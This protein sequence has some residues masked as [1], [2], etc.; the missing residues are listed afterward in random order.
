MVT[1][2]IPANVDKTMSIIGYEPKTTFWMDFSIA[3]RFGANAIKDTYNRAFKEWK[4][5]YIYLTELVIVLNHKI[6]QWYKINKTIASVYDTLWKEADLYAQ[7][8]LHVEEL[9]Y[10]YNATD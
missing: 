1:I 10:F 8:N 6:W 4:T 9:N 2:Q 7:E 5:N 3:D